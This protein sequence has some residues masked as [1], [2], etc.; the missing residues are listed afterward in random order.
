[1]VRQVMFLQ[2]TFYKLCYTY[3]DLKLQK[4]K[5]ALPTLI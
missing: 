1:M 4:Q 3:L 2:H 5:T